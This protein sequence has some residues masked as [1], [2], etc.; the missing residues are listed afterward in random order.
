MYKILFFYDTPHFYPTTIPSAHKDTPGY[1]VLVENHFSV[2]FD[3]VKSWIVFC[4]RDSYK[5]W[6]KMSHESY[7]SFLLTFYRQRVYWFEVVEVIRRVLLSGVL[8]LLGPGSLAQG[9]FSLFV[10]FLS[11]TIYSYVTIFTPKT[12]P[13]KYRHR[14]RWWR[15]AA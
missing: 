5:E 3:D 8:I 11:I 1:D 6:K 12:P 14:P 7:L 2:I 15:R 4:Y 9:I 10:C 13:I